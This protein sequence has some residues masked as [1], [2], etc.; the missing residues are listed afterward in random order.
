MTLAVRGFAGIAA[1]LWAICAPGEGHALAA[2]RTVALEYSATSECPSM[3]EFQ[4]T[5]TERLGYDAFRKDAADHVVV[6]IVPRSRGFEGR[7]EWRDPEGQWVGDRTFS[8]H[9][10]HCAELARAMAFALAMSAAVTAPM[11]SRYTSAAVTR[12]WNARPARIAALA[13]ASKPSTS[14]EGSA[15]A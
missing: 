11:P 2:E 4:A 1:F 6:D 10:E 5:V 9:G 12:V 14:A 8:P 3:L 15:S 13:A 7:I